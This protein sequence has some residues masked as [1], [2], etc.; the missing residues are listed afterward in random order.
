MLRPTGQ[1]KK[2]KRG[3]VRPVKQKRK[4]P[5]LVA[6]GVWPESGHWEVLDWELAEK[7]TFEGW[8]SLLVR[9]E[10]RGV[11][12]ERGVD[13]VIHD[14]GKGLIAALKRIYPSIPRQRCIFHK[15]RNI[16]QAIAVPEGLS[17][18]QVRGFRQPIIQQAA[19][20]YRAETLQQACALRDAFRDCWRSTQPDVVLAIERDWLETVTFYRLLQRFRTWRSSSLRTTS[21]LE[22]VNRKL[23]RLFRSANAYHSDLR[24]LAA[25]SR[26][27][28]PLRAA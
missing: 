6:V 2:D 19:A 27:L 13:L 3:R 10:A 15:L 5:V 8:E 1:Y 23:R 22:R 12:R 21:L 20:I 26:V 17:S 16:W 14:G 24:L 28:S 9:L 25:V 18:Q 11:Y 7:E 4:V